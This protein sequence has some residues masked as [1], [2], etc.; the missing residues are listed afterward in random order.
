MFS[1]FMVNAWEI[2]TIVAVVA[3]VVGFFVVLRG[4]AFPAHAIPN[5]AFAGAAGAN[6]LGVDPLVGLGVFSAA[7]R[8]RH[9]TAWA[10]GPA[11][12]RD[13]A[14]PGHDAR[15]RRRV[16]QPEQS[17]RAQIYA[18]LFGEV[19]GV[20]DVQLLPIAFLGMVCVA[21]MLPSTGRCCSPRSCRRSP[22]RGASAR[23]A[24]EFAFLVVVAAATTMTVPVVGALLIFSLMIGPP[25]AAR[26]LTSRPAVALGLSVVFALRSC[27]RRSR[28]RT[29]RTGRSA[30]SSARSAP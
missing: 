5:G 20:S 23:A 7:R 14:R 10:A 21:V 9:R 24:I 4:S 26:C 18:L 22:R 6:L 16:P 25:A 13:G 28:S 3:G 2:A 8:A 29:S 30:S 27:G 17:V 1:G 11:R 15:P 19:F 12:R